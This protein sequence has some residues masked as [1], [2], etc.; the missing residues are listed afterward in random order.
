MKWL[1]RLTVLVVAGWSG[2]WFI[3]ARAQENLFANLLADGRE[4]GCT[5]ESGDL[6]VGGFPY[7]FDT[8]LTDLSF[9]DPSGKWGWQADE[10]LITALTYQPN[11]VIAAWPGTQILDTPEGRVT[12]DSDVLRASIVVAP[13]INMPLERL[14]L[15]GAGLLLN[16]TGWMAN[17]STLNAALFQNETTPTRYR[18]GIDLEDITPPA[19]ITSR[20]GGGAYLPDL[21]DKLRLSGQIY[22]DREIDRP[23]FASAT[24]PRPLRA[25]IEPSFILWGPSELRLTGE[26]RAAE[27]GYVEGNLNFEVFNWQPFFETFRQASNLTT[28]EKLTL[29]RALDGASDGRNLAFTLNFINGETRIGPFTISPAPVYPF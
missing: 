8:S 26:L 18:L 17:I 2:Y 4:D 10:F 29:K 28:T 14:Q 23:A 24:P 12:V 6:G 27:N 19:F 13:A 5:A 1:F 3:G 15:E 21:V 20:L 7:R 16:G 11:H 22:F 25:T 9:R